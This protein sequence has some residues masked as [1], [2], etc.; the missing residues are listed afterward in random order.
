MRRGGK[1]GG[2]EVVRKGLMET[3]K[4]EGERRE[5]RKECMM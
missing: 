4:E 2:G 1:K 3:G 5:Q